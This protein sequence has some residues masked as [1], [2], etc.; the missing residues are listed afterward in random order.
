M[1]TSRAD[2]SERAMKVSP[3]LE[4]LWTA[5]ELAASGARFDP[6]PAAHF[7]VSGV[8][9]DSRSLKSGDLF[10][11]LRH[12]RDGH[13]FV[14][15]ALETG[16]AAAMVD[17]APVP[18]PGDA[19]LLFVEDTLKGLE[20]LGAAARDRSPAKR[21]AVTGS[22]GKT[23]TKE[24]LRLALAAS[25]ATHASEASYNNL[26]GVPLTL[27]RM[28][29]QTRYGVF[30]IGMNHAGEIT[31]LSR[32]VRPHVTI[33]TTVEPVHLEF[34]DSVEEI[35]EAKAEIF[36]GLEPGGA[37]ILNRDNPH[38]ARLALRAREAGAA[39]I[40]SFGEAPDAD[41]RL[42][43]ID[44]AP[45][46]SE[47]RAR[48]MGLDLSYRVS[49]PGRHI[50]HNSLAVLAGVVAL[51][52]DPRAAA[53]ALSAMR[54][55]TGRGAPAEIALPGGPLLLI[56]ESYNANP[57]SMRAALANFA[58]QSP[59]GGRRII[60]LGDMLELGPAAPE[61]HAALVSAI[62]SCG[63]DLVF[64]AGPMMKHLYDRLPPGLR[65]AYTPTAAE[66][67]EEVA[68]GVAPGDAIM[69]KGSLGS[70]MKTVVE[71][72]KG[73]DRADGPNRS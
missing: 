57:A 63:V 22:V 31:P 69:I 48:I 12:A 70:R 37:A 27:A 42:E 56:D 4:P 53:Q 44:L 55:Q 73:M 30:E 14:A 11:A 21:I 65:G 64:L 46:G 54:P 18:R 28:P 7:A 24:A 50:A 71:R 36:A 19:R 67:A 17:H 60:A 68:A 25:G 1:P 26:W 16:A 40:I 6:E 58:L 61:L 59:K 20:R 45:D 47:I 51:G 15:Q 62:E 72:L 5:K 29:R 13:E 10:V 34:F 8:S 23:G 3:M 38:F 66:L 33:I 32:Q 41:A 2:A 49:S 52:A 43:E 35:A 9:I 39:R